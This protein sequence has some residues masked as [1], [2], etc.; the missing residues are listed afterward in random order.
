MGDF[1]EL[2]GDD[3]KVASRVLGI[4]L[5]SRSKGSDAMPMAGVPVKA[6]E[7]HLQTL[8]REG[9]RVALCD[10]VQDPR[11]AKGIVDRRVTRIIT[12]G[13]I[14]ED[15]LLDQRASNFLLGVQ[16][17][18]EQAGMAWLDVS[19]GHFR[20]AVVPRARLADEVSRL[21]PAEVLVPEGDDGRPGEPAAEL[22]LATDAP[23]VAAPAW[24]FGTQNALQA[25]TRALDVATLEGFGVDESW[26]CVGAAGALLEYVEHTQRGLT[27]PVSGLSVHDPAARAGLDRATR[28]C[29]EILATQREGRRE[30]SLLSVMD[31]T[32]TGMGARR[33]REWLVAPLIDPPSIERRQAAVAELVTQPAVLDTLRDQ[34]DK[35]P[36]IERIATRLLAGRAAPRDLAGLRTGLAT[37]PVLRD[38]LTSCASDALADAAR[39]LTPLPELLDVLQRGLAE[40]PAA[41]LSEGGLIAPGWHAE[42]DELRRL[43]SSGAEEVA[44]FQAAEAKR[45]GIASLKVAY[46]KVFG[47][48]VEITHAQAAGKT[49]PDNYVRKQTLTS[50]ERYIT[51][52]L[53]ELETSILTAEERGRTLEAQLFGELRDRACR[54]AEAIRTL[55]RAVAGVDVLAGFAK[56]ARD[57]A[58]VRP[59]IDDGPRLEIHGGRHP[60]LDVLMPAGAFVPN[61]VLLDRDEARLVLITGP[62][63][64]GKSTFIRQVALLTLLAQ[65]GSF[66]PADSAR[67]GVVDRI[68]TRVGAA[69]DLSSGQS[70]FM[71]EMTETAAILNGASERSLVILDEVGRGTSTGDGLSL[72]W[73]ISEYL[74]RKVGART[75]F[76][77]HYH[78]LV[79]LAE[80]FDAVRN[81]NVAVREWGDEIVFQ[82]KI[83]PGGT[84]RSYGLHVARLAGVPKP[85]IERARAILADL[86]ASAPDLR[87]AAGATAAGG[88][89]PEP[90]QEPLFPKPVAAVIAELRGLDA[91]RLAPLEALLLLKR[92]QERLGPAP[93]GAS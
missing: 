23:M 74:Y 29:L 53:K 87:P 16:V 6:Y 55:A 50:A 78:E 88:A 8:I 61:D 64:A 48:Y 66:V 51:P 72:A 36:D 42:L 5:T 65:C 41:T 14:F 63:M 11:E 44:R 1:Y 22:A 82:H 32:S 73:A 57:R 91:D 20:V 70:T 49:L 27:A 26:P 21:D 93:E 52:E 15:D 75:L 76:A 33:L 46:N 56:L 62:N 92:L 13:T 40:Q 10:Q 3:A 71:V 69:D 79:D 43:R 59:V 25:L 2:F 45:L 86:E 17:R 34:L 37:V 81:V 12:A 84:D 31:G 18:G 89:R 19:T 47:Y 68:F 67:I 54:D 7:R 77:T 85:V 4:T 9:H 35:L 58:W 24:S 90:R 38:T 80:E 30:G 39:Q 28:S 60:V 83:V